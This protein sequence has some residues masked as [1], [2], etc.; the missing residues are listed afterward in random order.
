MSKEVELVDR[1]LEEIAKDGT[2]AYGVAQVERA[3]K[4]GAVETLLVASRWLK[5]GRAESL[6]A[7]SQKNATKFEIISIEHEHGQQLEAMGGLGALLRYR[8]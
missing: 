7:Q 3:L 4:A 5:E 1:W 6:L 8:I 2:A